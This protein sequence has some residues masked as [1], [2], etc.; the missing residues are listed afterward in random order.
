MIFPHLDGNLVI[1][2]LWVLGET[3]PTYYIIQDSQINR[4]ACIVDTSFF[5]EIEQPQPSIISSGE[6]LKRIENNVYSIPYER[7]GC[8]LPNHNTSTQRI[9]KTRTIAAGL[10]AKIVLW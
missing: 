1:I 3:D 8:M 2:H 10:Q 6:R 7:A 5:S 4:A 9:I